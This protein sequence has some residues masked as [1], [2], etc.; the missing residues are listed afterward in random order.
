[1]V[2]AE[3]INRAEDIAPVNIQFHIHYVM[4]KLRLKFEGNSQVVSLVGSKMP[5]S[6]LKANKIGEY[7][8]EVGLMEGLPKMEVVV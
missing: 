7:I 8:L 1:M 3:F 6:R 2:T 4:P 5:V